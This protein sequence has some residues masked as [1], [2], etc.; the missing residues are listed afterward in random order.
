[1]P[2]PPAQVQAS[3][4]RLPPEGKLD[5]W[6]RAFFPI[7]G[8][9]EIIPTPGKRFDAEIVSTPVGALRCNRVSYR[10]HAIHRTRQQVARVPEEFHV[11]AL[12][13]WGPWRMCVGREELELAPGRLYLLSNA[14]PY[15]SH[16]R[17]GYD[18]L[19]V[20]LPSRLLRRRIPELPPV[21]EM[22]LAGRPGRG[23]LL[24]GYLRTLFD[25]LP[26]GAGDD[27]GFV[28]GHLL[29]LVAHTVTAE[30][31]GLG[32]EDSSVLAAHRLRVG[33]FVEAHLD[34]EELDAAA[35]AAGCGLSVSYLYRVMQPGGRGV[36][37]YLRER[38]LAAARRMLEAPA[39]AG[40][41]VS[42]IAYRHGFRSLSD[43][44][45]AFKRRYG[46]APS[47][48]RRRES[49]PPPAPR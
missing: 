5:Y 11:L 40:L 42:E 18:T 47:A 39:A 37:E 4:R 20:M 9:I 36:R 24:A 45:R 2:K 6:R 17:V 48:L 29:D 33:R 10:G 19:N 23:A 1:M 35:I 3:T 49:V 16:D 41:S 13:T 38:R 46:Q 31:R 34:C 28:E 8:E 27:G 32:S 12:P 21:L 22:P 44:S 14:V 30:G 25:S 26:L 15:R 7:W 43:F